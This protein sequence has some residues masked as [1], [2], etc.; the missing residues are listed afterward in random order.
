MFYTFWVVAASNL[1][2]LIFGYL[3]VLAYR[4]IKKGVGKW[5]DLAIKE[6]ADSIKV[7]NLKTESIREG[8]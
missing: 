6:I 8:N 1:C 5:V 3:V 2:S 4:E 7:E